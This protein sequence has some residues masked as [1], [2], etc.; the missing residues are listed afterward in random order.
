MG[1]LF[2]ALVIRGFPTQSATA[3]GFGDVMEEL[4]RIERGSSNRKSIG[5]DTA[6]GFGDVMEELHRIEKGSSKR[7]RRIRTS[8]GHRG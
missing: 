3:H 4:H 1:H 2:V 7:K 5:G 6:R 8:E